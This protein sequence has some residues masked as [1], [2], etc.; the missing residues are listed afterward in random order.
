M[1]KKDQKRALK[2]PHPLPALGLRQFTFAPQAWISS[3]TKSEGLGG[4]GRVN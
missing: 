2:R 1:I 3:P 4:T